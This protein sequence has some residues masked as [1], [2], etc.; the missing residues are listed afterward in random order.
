MNNNSVKRSNLFDMYSINFR[1]LDMCPSLSER[2]L[3]LNG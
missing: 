3:A 1:P 2:F